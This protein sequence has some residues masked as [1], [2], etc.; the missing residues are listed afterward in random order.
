MALEDAPSDDAVKKYSDSE[1]QLITK[2]G[3]TAKFK[4]LELVSSIFS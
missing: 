1:F 3:Y 2:G 4:V